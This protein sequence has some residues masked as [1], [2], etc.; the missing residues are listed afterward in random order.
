MLLHIHADTNCILDRTD[1]MAPV[2]V[3]REI[4]NSAIEGKMMVK[5]SGQYHSAHN[6]G[7]RSIQPYTQ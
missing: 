1:K 6:L 5:Y 4:L 7:R 3:A 2:A